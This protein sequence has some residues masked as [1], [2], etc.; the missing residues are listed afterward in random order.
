MYRQRTLLERSAYQGQPL[1]VWVEEGKQ[2][3]ADMAWF[4]KR[5]ES[6]GLN[7]TVVTG[8]PVHMV[9]HDELQPYE[10]IYTGK[11]LMSM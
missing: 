10:M 8:D 2:M 1:R 9:Y 4:A 7:I 3:E 11:Y 5:C 6:V